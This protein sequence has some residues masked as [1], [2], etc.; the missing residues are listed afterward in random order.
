[1]LK[2]ICKNH[3]LYIGKPHKLLTEKQKGLCVLNT[4][5]ATD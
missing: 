4:Q 1:M 5:T 3:G 2:L